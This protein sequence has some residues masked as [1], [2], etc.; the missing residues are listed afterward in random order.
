MTIDMPQTVWCCNPIASSSN[1]LT[2]SSCCGC[3]ISSTESRPD[4]SSLNAQTLKPQVSRQHLESHTS[5]QK[6]NNLK[7]MTLT[8]IKYFKRASSPRYC[9]A[10]RPPLAII[11]SLPPGVDKSIQCRYT[12]RSLPYCSVVSR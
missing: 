9:I 12:D 10:T 7:A 3:W 1:C 4:T 5:R 8:T 6:N 11:R 2:P